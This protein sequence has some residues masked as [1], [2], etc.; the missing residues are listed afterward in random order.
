MPPMGPSVHVA[1]ATLARTR[2]PDRSM[3]AIVSTAHIPREMHYFAMI[4][5]D[6]QHA[7]IHRLAPSGMSDYGIAAATPLSAEMIR[8]ILGERNAVAVTT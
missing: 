5:R 6:E 7:A 3:S 2:R 4:S 1:A 8:A